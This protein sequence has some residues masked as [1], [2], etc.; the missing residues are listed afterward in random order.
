MAL[1]R[2]LNARRRET[3]NSGSRPCPS[4]FAFPWSFRPFC[5]FFLRFRRDFVAEQ[6]DSE[7]AEERDDDEEVEVS[8]GEGGLSEKTAISARLAFY[9]TSALS[10]AVRLARGA[11][12]ALPRPNNKRAPPPCLHSR[13]FASSLAAAGKENQSAE[14]PFSAVLSSFT[15]NQQSRSSET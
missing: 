9:T 14:L 15:Q 11:R 3:P 8:T 12:H 4:C 6:S 1:G 13:L 2:S 5:W 10:A 7:E